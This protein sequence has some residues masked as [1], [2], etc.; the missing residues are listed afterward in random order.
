MLR[1]Q[2]GCFTSEVDLKLAVLRMIKKEFPEFLA[3]K[4]SD[5][6]RS[7][8]P[9]LWIIG[10]KQIHIVELK[11]K[12]GDLSDIQTAMFNNIARAGAKVHVC[13]SVDDVRRVL[14]GEGDV[15]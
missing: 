12:R 4:I 3:V 2:S 9:D 10:K 15:C 5:K 1:M 14:K 11:T 7:G 13:C 6:F 8:V